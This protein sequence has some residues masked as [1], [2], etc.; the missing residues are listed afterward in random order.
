[1]AVTA[2]TP[3]NRRRTKMASDNVT[4]RLEALD[5]YKKRI[6][7]KIDI[8][9]RHRV[10]S[11]FK[12]VS[13][14]G[15]NL[16]EVKG[17]FGDPQG[18]YQ[19]DVD[20]PSYQFVSNFINMKSSGI[21]S[22]SLT[23]PIDPE[24]VKSVNF[25]SFASLEPAAADLLRASENVLSFKGKKG[26]A[27]YDALDADPIRKAGML[28]IFVKCQATG[29]GTDSSV[30]SHIRELKELR[31]DRFFAV[32]S[33]ELR[34]ETK[35][36]VAKG[37]FHEADQSLHTPDEGFTNRGSFKTSDRYGN[38]QLSFSSNGDEWRADIDIDDAGGFEHVFQVLRNKLSGKPT[39]PYNIHEILVQFQSLDPGYRFVV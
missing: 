26:K 25:P 8:M 18:A 9:L 6:P 21:T 37:L 33:K 27:L 14:N 3:N 39:H 31:G 11:Q 15:A 20:P 19:L 34:S 38:L 4:L 5:V 28:N 1:M 36:S 29:F 7:E 12:R 35:N 22:M 17:L 32:V 23:L 13:R 30:L 24:K 16:M 2:R 10:L